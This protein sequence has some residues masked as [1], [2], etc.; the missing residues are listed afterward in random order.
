MAHTTTATMESGAG[1]SGARSDA[2]VA[3]ADPLFTPWQAAARIGLSPSTLAKRRMNGT[4][5]R[6]IRLSA[7]RVAYRQSAIDAWLAERERSST[8]ET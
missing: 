4:G 1:R 3:G 5:P 7:T 8:L 2:V 6:F